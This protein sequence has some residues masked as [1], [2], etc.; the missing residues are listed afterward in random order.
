MFR[1]NCRNYLIQFHMLRDGDRSDEAHVHIITAVRGMRQQQ[2]ERGFS[3]NVSGWQS[4]QWMHYRKITCRH[5]RGMTIRW[6]S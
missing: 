4:K 5:K 1:Q 3:A 6:K 2:K